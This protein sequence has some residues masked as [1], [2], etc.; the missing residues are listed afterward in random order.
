MAESNVEPAIDLVVYVQSMLREGTR[1]KKIA[2]S[3]NIHDP[4]NLK[5]MMTKA[6]GYKFR[7]Y[8]KFITEEMS[9]KIQDALP[10][11]ENDANGVIRHVKVK[12][13]LSRLHIR[14]PRHMVERALQS[15]S[16]TI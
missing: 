9:S 12:A 13:A 6:L 5:R 4:R 8:H 1:F 16:G 14:A 7:V 3:L 15:I 10:I 2:E 11:Q